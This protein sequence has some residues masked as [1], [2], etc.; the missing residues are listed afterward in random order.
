MSSTDLLFF[1]KDGV[2]LSVFHDFIESCGGKSVL[3]DH[4]TTD[5]CNKFLK[6]QTIENKLSYCDCLKKKNDFLSYKDVGTADVFI[7]HAWKFNFLDVIATLD[8]FFQNEPNIIIWFD[9]FSNNQH[10]TGVKPFE[11]WQKTFRSAISQFG[12]VVMVLSPWGNPIPLTRAWCLFELFCSADTK[13][14]FEIA[15]TPTETENFLRD[16]SRNPTLFIDMVSEKCT[17]YS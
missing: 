11:W 12:R 10:D 16:M 4:T 7:S 9:L 6:L 5:V 13:S 3:L 1:P 8:Y 17:M 14:R 15:M 2:K